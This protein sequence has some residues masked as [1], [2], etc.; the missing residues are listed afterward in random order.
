MKNFNNE[1]SRQEPGHYFTDG[2]APPFIKTMKKL[3]HRFILWI[4]IE[5][6][7]SEFSRD[8]RHVRRLPC[9]DV[10]VLTDELDERAFLFWIQVST[11]TELL[12]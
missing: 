6:V 9:K 10:S 4:N 3:L 7:L 8:T 1:P 5:S 11:D 12:G 2:L